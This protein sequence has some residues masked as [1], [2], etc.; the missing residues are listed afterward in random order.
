MNEITKIH[1]GRQAFTIAVDAHKELQEYLRAIKKHM[2]D[3]D[4]AVEE[5]EL[6][7]AEL[8]AE[9]GVTGD[10]VVL[11][12][13][14]EYLKQQLGKPGDFGDEEEQVA[15]D[16][17]NAPKRL[18]RDTQGAIIAG[19]AS[20]LGKYFGLDPIWFRLAFIALVFAGGS[21]ALIYIIM[22]LIMPEAKTKS[23]R[24]QM[25]GKSVTVDTLKGVV[26]RA[27]VEG[28]AKRAGTAV[29]KAVNIVLKVILAVVGAAL[30]TAGVGLMMALVA[31]SIYFFL[32]HS[33]VVPFGIFPVGSLEYVLIGAAIVTVAMIGV[34]LLTAGLTVIKRHA[35]LP[36]WVMAAI[37][38]LFF[39]S[40]ATGVALSA[41]T[42]PKIEQRYEAAHHSD[43]RKTA[44]FTNISLIDS[45]GLPRNVEVKH[46]TSSD[47]KIEFRYMGS[48]DTKDVTIKEAKPGHLEINISGFRSDPSCTKSPCLFTGRELTVIV[49]TPA[50]QLIKVHADGNFWWNS[51][52]LSG[53]T[54]PPEPAKPAEWIYN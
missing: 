23:D 13:D 7:M 10:K 4:D 39:S 52:N 31:S 3:S 44:P 54:W 25:Q 19:V 22:W 35:V 24:L 46:E 47:Y 17:N 12:K 36:G 15:A 9:R 49:Y 32:N 34:F 2:G 5:V 40:V 37:F 26:E 45:D 51:P 43:I 42:T 30:L 8:L 16:D 48:A 50:D 21:G 20:G 1:L 38:A 14:V 27:D 29:G 28:A 41:T 18:F 53:E 33:A 11:L 6:R